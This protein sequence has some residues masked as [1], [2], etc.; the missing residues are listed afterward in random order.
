MSVNQTI[1][2]KLT[3]TQNLM[4]TNYRIN[5]ATIKV[6]DLFD[7]DAS[8]QSDGSMLLYNGSTSKWV[9]TNQMDNTNTIINGGNF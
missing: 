7:V 2:A 6:D 8:A 9:A 1:K 3:P 4:V 5:T